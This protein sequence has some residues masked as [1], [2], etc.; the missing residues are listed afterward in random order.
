[1]NDRKHI[2]EAEAGA[3]LLVALV[4][5]VTV[6]GFAVVMLG[7]V[8]VSNSEIRTDHEHELRLQIAESGLSQAIAAIESGLDGNIGSEAAPIALNGGTMSVET[9]RSGD[10]MWTIT[11]TGSFAGHSRRLRAVLTTE[12]HVFHHAIFAGNDSGDPDYL[13]PFSGLGD[14]GD[15]IYGDIYSGGNIEVAED[16]RIAGIARA[17][18]TVRGVEADF[19]GGVSQPNPDFADRNYASRH[20][21]NVAQEFRS[22]S[23]YQSSDAGGSAYQLPSSHPAHIFRLNPSDR[24]TETR[25]TT[26]DDYFLEDPY[27]TLRVD[28]SQDG[29][30]PY[31][32]SFPDSTPRVYYID[33]NLWIHNRRSYSLAFSSP[34]GP[35]KATIVVSGNIYIS[36]NLFYR[37]RALDGVAFIALRDES[38]PDSGNVYFGDPSFGTLSSMDAFLFA[39]NNFHDNNLSASGSNYIDLFGTM[40]AGNQ[41]RIDRGRGDSH[42]RLTVNWD[43]RLLTGALTL[44]GI[45]EANQRLSFRRSAWMEISAK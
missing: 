40:S 23:S 30:D 10:N 14:R 1:M 21:I 27:E 35:A 42:S 4:S 43:D 18:G 19:E 37:D 7:A 32:L 9:A 8:T 20:D 15:R 25:S 16:A 45:P 26:K 41:V 38:V 13:M 2:R 44:P 31:I 24:T 5:G 33:G 17:A 3:A 11:S 36:D 12:G 29:T 28:R 34:S 6:A 39:E 22:L